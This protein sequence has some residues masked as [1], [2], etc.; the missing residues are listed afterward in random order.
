MKQA[1]GMM[2]HAVSGGNP[3]SFL[4]QPRPYQPASPLLL[5]RPPPPPPPP[6]PGIANEMNRGVEPFKDVVAR[7]CADKGILFAPMPGKFHEGKQ[8]YRCGNSVVYVDKSFIFLQRSGMWLHTS[9]DELL[10]KAL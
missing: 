7:R 9:L 8:I 2:N 5:N 6:A 4:P 10:S 3:S 1:L